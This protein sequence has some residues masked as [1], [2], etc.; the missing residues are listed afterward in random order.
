MATYTG[1]DKRLQYLFENGGGGGGGGTTVV[2][3]PQGTPTDYLNTIKIGNSILSIANNGDIYS[4]QEREIGVWYDGK[5]L[6]QRTIITP[7]SSKTKGSRSWVTIFEGN[8]GF[9][10]KRAF[11]TITIDNYA[12]FIMNG[13]GHDF[14]DASATNYA[15][16]TYSY[17][18]TT[19]AL[20]A[21]LRQYFYDGTASGYFTT[22]VQYTKNADTAGSGVWTPSGAYARH[23]STD[24]NIIGTYLGKP[25]Y[26][27][28]VTGLNVTAAWQQQ[29]YPNVAI[30]A[31]IANVKEVVN[32]R[33]IM[34]YDN[35]ISR[36]SICSI[37]INNNNDT[38]A[39]IVFDDITINS[40]ILEYTKT[41]D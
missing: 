2:P 36:N 30:P 27:K 24:E 5:P 6:Y 25:L 18:N 20:S 15:Y 12:T 32:S 40:L 37:I 9:S 14:A 19:G 13:V 38:W 28:V 17:N 34:N 29:Y 10:P 21:V 11:G 39:L 31:P 22:T 16:A 26:S 41:T 3:N 35:G 33:A 1:A 7:F 8:Q 4:E 23:Y